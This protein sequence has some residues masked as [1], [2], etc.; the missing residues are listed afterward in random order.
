[1]G[2][3]ALVALAAA[4]ACATAGESPAAQPP[5]SFRAVHSLALVRTLDG[6]AGRPK[7]PLDGL[8]ESLRARGYQTRVV[9]LGPGRKPELAA[10]EKLFGL[11]ELRAAVGRSERLGTP[12]YADAGRAAG[13]AVEALGVD[14]VATYHRL[15]R[16]HSGP[17]PTADPGLPGQM[18][19]PP[20]PPSTGPIGALALVDRSGHVA[21][22]PWGEPSAL[23]DPSVPMNAA[24]AIDFLV[25]S[26]AGEAPPED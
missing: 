20:A 24:E 8:D 2:K 15:D 10:V 22:F 5:P 3:L 1:M 9:E 13:A 7:D 16:R 14:A 17:A 26:L 21:T 12:P 4:T 6:R 23:E 19:P 11:L 18:F 25:R